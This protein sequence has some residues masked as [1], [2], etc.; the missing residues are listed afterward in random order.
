MG[1]N[2]RVCNNQAPGEALTVHSPLQRPD[3]PVRPGVRTP[4]EFHWILQSPASLAGMSYPSSFTPW[5]AIAARA[6]AT[7]CA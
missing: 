5:L 3:M 4:Y 7:S 6:F 1:K 2:L